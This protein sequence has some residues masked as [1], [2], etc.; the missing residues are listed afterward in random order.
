M[1]HANAFLSELNPEPCETIA[2]NQSDI[3]LM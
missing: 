2:E 1:S 3:Y